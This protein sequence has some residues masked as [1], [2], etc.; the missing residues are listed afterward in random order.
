VEASP[1]VSTQVQGLDKLSV[2]F[3]GAPLSHPYLVTVRI[4]STG[5]ADI[6]SSSFDGGKPVLFDVR[7]PVLAQ[8]GHWSS[9]DTVGARLT[10]AEG[11]SAVALQP[12]LLPKGHLMR[13]AYLCDG[14]PDVVPRIELADISIRNQF[15]AAPSPAPR[16]QRYALATAAGSAI[17]ATLA[18]VFSY[19]LAQ[20][21]P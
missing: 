7:V 18:T 16:Y 3:D 15:R 11:D 13:A 2:A 10:F 1:L 6:S 4:G 21:L 8:L 19:I 17:L 20:Q 14:E 9:S 12:S 5:R